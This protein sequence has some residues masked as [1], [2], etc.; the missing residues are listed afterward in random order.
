MKKSVWIPLIGLFF[1]EDKNLDT[2]FWKVVI[3]GMY[4]VTL[5]ITLLE[6]IL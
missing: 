1:F 2:H 5:G 4:Q 3:C 6:L